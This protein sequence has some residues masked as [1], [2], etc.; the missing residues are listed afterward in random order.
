MPTAFAEKDCSLLG[1]YPSNKWE[2]R[3]RAVNKRE[4]NTAVCVFPRA[5]EGAVL[6]SDQGTY[7]GRETLRVDPRAS[8]SQGGS[9]KCALQV[10]TPVRPAHSGF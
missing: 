8:E 6:V 10:S 1:V 5:R 4:G 2:E 3:S 7:P 9:V